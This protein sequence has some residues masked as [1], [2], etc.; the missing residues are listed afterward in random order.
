[1]HIRRLTAKETIWRH[2]HHR[3]F[4]A[5]DGWDVFRCSF[6]GSTDQSKSA[7]D[8]LRISDIAEALTLDENF[9]ATLHLAESGRDAQKNW[10]DIVAEEEASIDPVDAVERDFN[11]LWLDDVVIRRRDT[12]DSD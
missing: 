9:G 6:S 7:L 8:E 4:V 11:P 10:L 5:V 1:M 2:A 12:D 3:L